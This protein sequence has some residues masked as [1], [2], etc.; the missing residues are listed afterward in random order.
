MIP[1]IEFIGV[2]GT[3]KSSVID[4]IEIDS[5]TNIK[6]QQM[7]DLVSRKIMESSPSWYVK[8]LRNIK[9]QRLL[10]L[11]RHLAIKDLKKPFIA[12]T[13]VH[14][15]FISSQQLTSIDSSQIKRKKAFF[16]HLFW[17]EQAEKHELGCV[18]VLDEG[19]VKTLFNSEQALK[20]VGSSLLGLVHIDTEPGILRESL[21]NRMRKGNPKGP[22]DLLT[23][24][25]H[26]AIARLSVA[27][28]DVRLQADMVNGL[29]VPVLSINY[30]QAPAE[31]IK[32]AEA[33]I[34]STTF[35][36]FH[37]EIN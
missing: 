11:A 10:R 4:S 3:G 31:A 18:P 16:E 21:V 35:N 30:H 32:K 17:L 1:R 9:T 27:L 7:R 33:F 22:H 19:L 8:I 2:A 5:S 25:E 15:R 20:D 24:P 6:Y 23:I 36:Y 12:N 26:E 34:K 14:F 28:A 13:G 29:G 37:G